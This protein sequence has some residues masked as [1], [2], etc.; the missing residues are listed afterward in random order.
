MA[1]GVMQRGNQAREALALWKD[2]F[3]VM[4]DRVQRCCRA[5]KL[6]VGARWSNAA[7]SWVHLWSF[8]IAEKEQ[9]VVFYKFVNKSNIK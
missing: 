3:D 9:G 5:G 7:S 1:E 8:L 4:A 2:G 6:Q